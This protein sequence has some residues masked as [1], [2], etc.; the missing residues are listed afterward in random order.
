MKINFS[1]KGFISAISIAACLPA[2]AQEPNKPSCAASEHRQFDFWLGEWSV[3][4]PDGS[5]AGHNSIRQEMGQCVL[6]ERWQ[7]A[8]SPFNGESFNTFD[9][10]RGVWHQTWVDNSGLLLLLEGGL[11]G[12]S[13]LL[14]GS[15]GGT[16]SPQLQKITWTPNKNATVRQHW[17]TSSDDGKTWK[18]AFDGLYS[19]KA[20]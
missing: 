16:Q 6:H 9:A 15:T 13:M 11:I 17:Q 14:Q 5:L 3:T 10:A 12:E 20:D 1:L 4:N 2:F 19:P 7:S 18:T 8:T